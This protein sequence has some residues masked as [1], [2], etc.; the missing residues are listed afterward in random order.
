LPEDKCGRR[1]FPKN[2]YTW[3]ATPYVE[4]HR[5]N[6]QHFHFVE[7][8]VY[9]SKKPVNMALSRGK[10]IVNHRGFT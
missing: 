3:K 8:I 2:A 1:Q 5:R 4:I 9:T 7:R 6:A 10:I